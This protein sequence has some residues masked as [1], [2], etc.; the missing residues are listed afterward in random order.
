MT[1]HQL[2][3]KVNKSLNYVLLERLLVLL[4]MTGRAK[5]WLEITQLLTRL[6]NERPRT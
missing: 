3:P 5:W 1:S 2:Q 6:H 4:H